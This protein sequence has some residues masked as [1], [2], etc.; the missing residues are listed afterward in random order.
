MSEYFDLAVDLAR[1]KAAELLQNNPN[2]VAPYEYVEPP[3]AFDTLSMRAQLDI[4][5]TV[6]RRDPFLAA[7]DECLVESDDYQS[8]IHT[9]LDSSVSNERVGLTARKIVLAYLQ[10]VAVNHCQDLADF[11]E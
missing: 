6:C 4:A 1:A 9:L 11:A 8:F 5:E 2:R 3:P 10:R 7:L